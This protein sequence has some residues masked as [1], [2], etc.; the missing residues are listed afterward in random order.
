M[1][2]FDLMLEC[3]L[4][5]K[6]KSEYI[7][8]HKQYSLISGVQTPDF[9]K[10]KQYLSQ[11]EKSLFMITCVNNKNKKV[12]GT[13][14]NISNN[15]IITL[16]NLIEKMCIEN[17][18]LTGKFRK[19]K[20]NKISIHPKINLAVLNVDY[21]RQHPLHFGEFEFCEPGT[22][23]VY[24]GFLS[25][26]PLSFQKNISIFKAKL[27]RIENI[28]SSKNISGVLNKKIRK[29]SLGAPLINEMGSVIGILTNEISKDGKTGIY[30]ID[31][32]KEL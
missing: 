5:L 22:N 6:Q 19:I 14:F 2:I 21:I 17:T 15:E 13:G 28:N 27:E 23:V 11:I 3:C 9:K 10:L 26:K 18:V 25:T 7:R 12:M 16:G 29:S 32:I 8:I 20:I 1:P 31:I 30:P 4:M 24:P